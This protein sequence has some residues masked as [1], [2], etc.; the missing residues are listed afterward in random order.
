M[1]L[2]YMTVLGKHAGVAY[3][4]LRYIFFNNKYH[5]IHLARL[6]SAVPKEMNGYESFKIQ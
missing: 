3:H 4:C 5:F 6:L 1:K 2:T